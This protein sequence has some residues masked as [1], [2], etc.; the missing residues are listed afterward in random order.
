[1]TIQEKGREEEGGGGS[2]VG[3]EETSLYHIER[4]GSRFYGEKR[5]RTAT[6]PSL[7]R[8]RELPYLSFTER[9]GAEAGRI[10][11]KKTETLNPH[12]TGKKEEGGV[13]TKCLFSVCIARHRK[14]D[15]AMTPS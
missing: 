3:C 14:E 9:G 5:L 7:F 8:E 13:Q 15:H 1:V 10:V 6:K 2:E 12:L 4:K 11:N